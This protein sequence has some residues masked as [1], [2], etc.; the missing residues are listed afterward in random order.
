M[1]KQKTFKGKA[2]EFSKYHGKRVAV[3]VAKTGA[4]AGALVGAPLVA[5]GMI[6][7]N[8]RNTLE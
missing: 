6:N 1:D 8:A 5:S 2:K 3:G 4:F 7:K